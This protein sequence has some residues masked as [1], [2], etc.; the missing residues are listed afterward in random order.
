LEKYYK[1][2][3][4]KGPRI[5]RGPKKSRRGA[6]P[7]FD[8]KAEDQLNDENVTPTDA[9]EKKYP[10]SEG[11]ESASGASDQCYNELNEEGD[12]IANESGSSTIKKGDITKLK[13]SHDSS[14]DNIDSQ[15]RPSLS[16]L[17]AGLKRSAAGES[18]PI[19]Q[20]Q[21][22]GGEKSPVK[23]TFDK[24]TA[25]RKTSLSS[26]RINLAK[27]SPAT[28]SVQQHKP[29]QSSPL[30]VHR[31]NASNVTAIEVPQSSSSPA[32]AQIPKELQMKPSIPA[33]KNPKFATLGP[34]ERKTM[35]EA[36]RAGVAKEQQQKDNAV[37]NDG[38][39]SAK[40]RNQSAAN[41][42]IGSSTIKGKNWKD[43]PNSP[44]KLFVEE[45][46]V[47]ETNL[48]AAEAAAVANEVQHGLAG[49]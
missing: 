9:T 46:L 23:K 16:L 45:V 3:K 13:T 18:N 38:L 7:E 26:K 31:R 49:S 47:D 35:M 1:K 48:S 14:V 21:E 39:G 37:E 8:E 19:N 2:P 12:D 43:M 22:Q 44:V 4:T 17:S 10:R 11:Y 28:T 5:I 15:K 36:W 29:T 41:N 33:F 34:K 30:A 40:T 32:V 24:D 6:I 27:V 20:E 25:Q 42:N